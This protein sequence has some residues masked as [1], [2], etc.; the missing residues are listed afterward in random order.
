MRWLALL[1]PLV[2]LVAWASAQ[3]GG[4]ATTRLVQVREAHLREKPS[5][6]GRILERLSY[7]SE[8]AV[9]E[10]SADSRWLRVRVLKGGA[11]SGPG[12]GWL[13]ASALASSDA[14]LKAGSG[15]AGDRAGRSTRSLAGR[16]FNADVEEAR[17]AR[18]RTSGSGVEAGYQKLD[19]LLARPAYMARPEEVPAF[20]REGQLGGG[21]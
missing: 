12:R 19:E 16:G 7:E 4:K 8:V 14:T 10:E 18:L 1:L 13:A 2:A 21:R 3:G 20:V 17:R 9:E 11:K 15:G 5:Y 6:L